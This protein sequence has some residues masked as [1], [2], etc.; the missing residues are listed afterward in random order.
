MSAPVKGGFWVYGHG[1]AFTPRVRLVA[2]YR[3]A[4]LN[5]DRVVCAVTGRDAAHKAHGMAPGR[6][7]VARTS[8]LFRSVRTLRGTCGRLVYSGRIT[9]AEYN[10]LPVVQP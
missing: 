9:S 2:R 8:D 6:E 1:F 3:D 7:I 4:F 5:C 10:A